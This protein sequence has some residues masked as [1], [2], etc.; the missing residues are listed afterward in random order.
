MCWEIKAWASEQETWKG[1]S[2]GV[3]VR[4]LVISG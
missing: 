2:L 3:E 1:T 4:H